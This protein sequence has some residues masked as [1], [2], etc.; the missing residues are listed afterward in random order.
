MAA[1]PS[2]SSQHR[3][4]A[5][6]QQCEAAI[7]QIRA[8]I[9]AGERD[10]PEARS[11]F[12]ALMAVVDPLMLRQASRLS[13]ISPA[14]VADAYDMMYD[15]LIAHLF[16]PTFPS[17]ETKF[18][19]YLVSMPIRVL[20]QVR[21]KYGRDQV[22]IAVERLDVPVRDESLPLYELIE[23]PQAT[24]AVDAL[25]DREVLA[26]AL[27]QLPAEERVAFTLR[28]EGEANNAIAQTLGV[29]PAT[30]TRLY[31]R[32]QRRLRVL[33]EPPPGVDAP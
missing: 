13:W 10:S 23:D 15:R 26:Q 18:G 20:G 4:I 6:I 16:S 8:A 33:L 12:E 14:A 3:G 2:S 32:A 29:S 27:A 19:A 21:R 11:A 7:R 30:A 9:R 5:R 25:A 22:S 28:V 31:Q 1:Q 24:G 17:L